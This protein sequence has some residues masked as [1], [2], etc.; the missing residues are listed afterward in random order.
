MRELPLIVETP[1]GPMAEDSSAEL[2]SRLLIEFEVELRKQGV[3]VDRY[4]QPG[5]PPEVVRASFAAAGLVAPDEVVAWFGW[6][7]GRVL[8]QDDPAQY[9]LPNFEFQSLQMTFA[10]RDK[11]IPEW[12]TDEWQW[13]PE[14]TPISTGHPQFTVKADGDPAHPPLVRCIDPEL[15]WGTQPNYTDHQVVSLCTPV[16]WW[17]EFLR[18]GEYQ[19]VPEHRKWERGTSKEDSLRGRRTRSFA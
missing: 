6:H 4:L 18:N 10:W 12:G 16:T 8:L 15:G 5:A 19:W 14:W 13:H 2:L 17:I 11:W 7:D 9:V 1:E 3:P